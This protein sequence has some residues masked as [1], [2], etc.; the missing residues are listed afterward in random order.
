M[1]GKALS[2][3][4]LIFMFVFSAFTFQ[5]TDGA[6]A[7]GSASRGEAVGSFESPEGDDPLV[8]HTHWCLI[9]VGYLTDIIPSVSGDI[10]SDYWIV[11]FD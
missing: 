3:A 2:T 4:A 7:Q 9:D 8:I 5:T 6:D 11:Q 10:E 1:Y